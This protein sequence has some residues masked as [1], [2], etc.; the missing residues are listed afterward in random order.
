[1]GPLSSGVPMPG[2]MVEVLDVETACSELGIDQ[3]ALKLIIADAERTVPE[4]ALI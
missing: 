4:I 3:V 2:D 1:M